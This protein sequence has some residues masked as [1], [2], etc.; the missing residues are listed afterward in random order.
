M[1]Y[2]YSRI[3]AVAIEDKTISVYRTDISTH[4]FDILFSYDM[5]FNFCFLLFYHSKLGLKERIIIEQFTREDIFTSKLCDY[6]GKQINAP[7]TKQIVHLH[8]VDVFGW[9]DRRNQ[10]FWCFR[11][12]KT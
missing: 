9:L 12:V 4:F 8:N 6:V 5:W 2:L 1:V 3:I 10:N 11:P 7:I